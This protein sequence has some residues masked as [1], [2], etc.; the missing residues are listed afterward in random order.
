[1]KKGDLD[2]V[3]YGDITVTKWK[4]RGKNPVNLLSN[5]HNGSE[6]VNILRTNTKG[7]RESVPR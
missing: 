6:K 4:E 2:F 5:M 1:M 3:Q 7:V